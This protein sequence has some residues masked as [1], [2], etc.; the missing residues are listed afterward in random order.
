M[1]WCASHLAQVETEP[2]V[3][4][5][6]AHGLLMIGAGAVVFDDARADDLGGDLSKGGDALILRGGHPLRHLLEAGVEDTAGL[7]P[8]SLLKPLDLPLRRDAA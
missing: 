3:A 7:I 6:H 1:L 5:E 4:S 2:A 8:P